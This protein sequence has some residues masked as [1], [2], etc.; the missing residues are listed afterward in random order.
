MQMRLRSHTSIS[1]NNEPKN[2]KNLAKSAAI[3]GG[4]LSVGVRHSIALATLCSIYGTTVDGSWVKISRATGNIG[5]ST[6]NALQ[7]LDNDLNIVKSCKESLDLCVATL[8]KLE[9][10]NGTLKKVEE[11]LVLR[12]IGDFLDNL[13]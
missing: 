11:L 5:D 4:V 12:E 8:Y 1:K 10:K 6:F 2:D 7:I 3:A 13:S 9:E